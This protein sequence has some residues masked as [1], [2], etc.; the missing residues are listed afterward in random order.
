MFR[1]I[2]SDKAREYY[3]KSEEVMREFFPDWKKN[4]YLS[5]LGLKNRLFLQ[6]YSPAARWIFDPLIRK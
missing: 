3:E 2:R 5:S 6:W 4:R 1:F